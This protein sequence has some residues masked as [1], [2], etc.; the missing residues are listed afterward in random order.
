MVH[1]AGSTWQ[2]SGKSERLFLF[3]IL[4]S[5]VDPTLIKAFSIFHLNYC[6]CLFPISIFSPARLPEALPLW[7][8]LCF[9][10]PLPKQS[11]SF[12]C[13]AGTALGLQI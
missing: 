3:F 5:P 2:N 4:P 13:A 10:L 7:Q 1:T 6:K 11:L 9:K 8:E 12:F